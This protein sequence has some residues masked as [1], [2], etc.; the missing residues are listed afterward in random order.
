[1]KKNDLVYNYLYKL[2]YIGRDFFRRDMFTVIRKYCKGNVLDVGGR[3]FFLKAKAHGVIFSRWTNLESTFDEYYPVIDSRYQFVVGDG[4]ELKFKDNT[5]ET[6]LN[7]HV[8]EHVF[9]PIQMVKETSRVLKKNGYAIF[10]IPNSATLHM[11]PHHYY[12]FTRFWIKK[13]MEDQGLKIIELKPLGGLW[14]TI[15]ARLFYFFLKSIRVS[16]MSTKYDRR[17]LV[18]YLLFPAACLYALVSIPITLFFSL[19]DLTEDP[20]DHLVVV[21]KR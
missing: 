8:L 14:Q 7:L 12:N 10:L 13:V 15:S 16:G 9:E 18:F 2:L 19:G 6:V 3:D 20:N 17:N 4:C 21:K 1:M 5:F 11:T